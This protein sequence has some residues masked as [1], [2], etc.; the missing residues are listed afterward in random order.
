MRG[1]RWPEGLTDNSVRSKWNR[2]L[3]QSRE[4]VAPEQLPFPTPAQLDLLKAALLPADQAAPAWKR[5]KARGLELRTVTDDAS[6]RLFPQLWTN[7]DAAGIG[8]EDS[9]LLK[10][11]YRRTFAGNTGRLGAGLDVSRLLTEAGIP[12]LFIKGAAMLAMADGR[13]GFRRI[14]DV[15]LLVPEIDAER[16][17]TALLAAGYKSNRTQI[18]TVGVD[19]AWSYRNA[20]GP[21]VDLHWWAFKLAGDDS[22]MFHTALAATLLGRQVLIPSATECLVNTVANAFQVYGSPCRWIADAMVLIQSADI[23]WEYVLERAWRPCVALGLSAGLSFLGREFGAPVPAQVLDELRGRPVSRRERCA[24]W[25][26]VNRPVVGSTIAEQLERY[27]ARRLHSRTDSPRN[28]LEH[29]TQVTG[30]HRRDVVRR[31]TR[32]AL[33]LILRAFSSLADRRAT[34]SYLEGQV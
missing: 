6:M 14:D 21:A 7:R 16:A 28:F 29:M 20:D 10:G 12:V 30:G 26:A 25:A 13:L 33:L 3:D 17:I 9:P 27:R 23:E 24:H 31:A 18:P 8:P 11:V 15:D 34:R 2:L 22:A 1:A 4:R 32:T 19:H 5:W